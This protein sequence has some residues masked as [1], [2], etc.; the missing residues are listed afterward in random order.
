M[1]TIFS[2]HRRNF[3]YLS[4]V[5]DKLYHIMLYTSA[6]SRFQLTTSVVIDT[7]CISSCKSNYHTITATT[8]PL[9][10][11][12]GIS[13][14]CGGFHIGIYGFFIFKSILMVFCLFHIKLWHSI[15]VCSVIFAHLFSFLCCVC[16]CPVSVYPDWH[17]LEFVTL[18]ITNIVTHW[19][20]LYFI[21]LV[22]P[23]IQP[24]YFYQYITKFHTML[25]KTEEAIMNQ[26]YV[27]KFVSNLWQV[28][29]FLR[30]D[31]TEILL[32]VALNTI[33]Q[34]CQKRMFSVFHI[35]ILYF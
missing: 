11:H 25:E 6:W 21:P 19:F 7:D 5:T 33:K 31:I 23:G 34:T 16:L 14:F 24:Y 26:H 8:A 28:G 30:H 15:K 13:C 2:N 9:F 10:W 4:Q 22:N 1:L 29:G 17:P 3:H 35:W 12:V 27:I 20:W 32:K 18:Q